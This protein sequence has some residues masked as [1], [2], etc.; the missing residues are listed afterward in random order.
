VSKEAA[1]I[2]PLTLRLIEVP[3]VVEP[4]LPQ[5]KP[6]S[7]PD[8]NPTQRTAP[9]RGR[10]L[11]IHRA[12]PHTTNEALWAA[13]RCVSYGTSLASRARHA[14][15]GQRIC[16]NI[17]ADT[18]P[19]LVGGPPSV[20]LWTGMSLSSSPWRSRRDC[21]SPNGLETDRAE[22]PLGR[23]RVTSESSGVAG[24]PQPLTFVG[25]VDWSTGSP[26]GRR[27]WRLRDTLGPRPMEK[28]PPIVENPQGP[29]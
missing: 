27:C 1:E 5:S 10:P 25:R 28:R 20:S 3:R 6:S 11:D 15:H 26:G 21:T 18:L 2:L 12:S 24:M 9:P 16:G 19:R 8:N 23:A 7:I 17:A 29:V 14:G 13:C 4:G 22:M